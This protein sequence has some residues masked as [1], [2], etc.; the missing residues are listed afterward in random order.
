MPI[1]KRYFHVS[2]EMNHDPELWHFTDTFG[3]RALRTWLQI[4]VILDRSQNRWRITDGCFETLARTVRQYPKNV[5]RQVE[6]LEKN[7]WLQVL[8]TTKDG[9][10]LVLGATNWLKY[11]RSQ[12]HRGEQKGAVAD[13]LLSV[14]IRSVPTPKIKE[15][16]LAPYQE[17][18]G[19]FWNAYPK[20]KGKGNVEK[21]FVKTQ[22]SQVLL[23][24]MLSKIMILAGSHEWTKE[25]GQFIPHPATWLNAKGWED[26][27]TANG[28]AE[29]L[30]CPHHP[31]K[32]FTDAKEKRGHDQI[33]HPKFE[34]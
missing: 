7:Q 6:E 14:P 29:P 33:Y 18:A 15:K 12:E 22:P 3:E 2:Q 25:R 16:T 4:L 26:E 17:R 31:A 1:P 28:H 20:K 34:G 13:P 9:A 21:W 27:L 24:Q 5:R 10:W 32:I 11:N 8:E 19:I 30:T 23:E